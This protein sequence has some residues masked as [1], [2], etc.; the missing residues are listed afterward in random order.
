MGV[1][2]RKS[3]GYPVLAAMTDAQADAVVAPDPYPACPPRVDC[4]LCERLGGFC[5]SCKREA[6]GGRRKPRPSIAQTT[7]SLFF[8]ESCPRCL[9]C[10]PGAEYNALAAAREQWR[11]CSERGRTARRSRLFWSGDELSI[12]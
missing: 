6:H 4:A 5:P 9:G 12:M 11:R 3:D 10:Q 1:R 8:S 7:P 2:L